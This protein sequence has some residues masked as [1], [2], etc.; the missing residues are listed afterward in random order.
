MNRSI[1][2]HGHFY[3]PP[4]E[5][6]WLE[7]VEVQDSAYPYHDWNERVCAESYAPN[8]ASRILDDR[9]LIVDIVNNYARISFD[10]GPTLLRWMEKAFPDVYQAIL[11]ADRDSRDKFGGH[12]GA[13]AQAY[14]HIIMPLANSRDKRTQVLWGIR[15]FE[16]RFGRK[17]EGM[18]LPET[19][20]D[21]ESLDLMAEQGLAFSLLSP[22]QAA[23]VRKVKAGEWRDVG[24]GR[25]DPK[26]P[27]LCRLP[28]GRS[29]ALFFYDGPIS[30]DVAFGD[31]LENGERFAQRLMGGFSPEAKAPEL[32]HIATDGETYGHHHRFGDMAL[33]YCLRYIEAHQLADQTVYGQYLE[34][35]PPTHEVKILENTAWSCAHGVDR[36]RADC[37]DSTGA[38]PGWNQKWRAPLREAM[39]WLRDRA[40]SIFEQGLGPRVQD[41]WAVRDDYIRVIL[42][43]S[44]QTVESFFS[45]HLK[46]APAA[47]ERTRILKLLEMQRQA[48][49]IFSSDGWFFDDI[50]SIETVQVMQYAARLLQLARDVGGSDLEPE[51]LRRLEPA[52]SNLPGQENGARV[53]ER[54]VN[55][56]VVDFPRLGAHYAVSSLFEDYPQE[57]RIAHYEASSEGGEKA[58]LGRRRLATGRVKLKSEITEEEKT[59]TYAVLHFGDQNLMAGVKDSKD[60]GEFQD[61]EG[62]IREAFQRSDMT[63]VVRLIDQGFGTRSYSLWHLFRDEKRNVIRKIL[64]TNLRELEAIFR[65]IFESNYTIMQA[66]KE[67]QIPLPE[68]LST[69]AQFVL[70]SDFRALMETEET[71]GDRL[72]KLMDEF[73]FWSFKPDPLTMD[74]ITGRKINRLMTR[75]AAEPDDVS[76]LKSVE[77]LFA[78]LQPLVTELDLRP[79]QNAFFRIGKAHFAQTARR[80]ASGDSKARE[81]L[82]LFRVVGKDLRFDPAVFEAEPVPA[83]G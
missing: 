32:V 72:A 37:G 10:A 68:A 75:W 48:M 24:G 65:Q 1:C 35:H 63:A 23:Q 53:Y 18:W 43:R 20:V 46:S 12:G 59:M 83:R 11:Q 47:E 56:S 13:M 42:D 29:I 4:R 71:D 16:S 31:I 73:G 80:A 70:N 82:D 69:P 30:H 78:S 64:E 34:Q 60:K 45:D 55:P 22:Y 33:A 28:S 14:N 79:S 38:H 62:R 7:E 54:Q 9:D 58:V 66:L 52:R 19:A 40:A 3:Q 41:P 49:L 76:A 51:F 15:D 21:L 17:P 81:W 67:M 44:A 2:I 36:W 61:L 6:A 26:R 50:S 27:Y 39:D 77:R 5:N 57:V 25:I 8:A 74:F